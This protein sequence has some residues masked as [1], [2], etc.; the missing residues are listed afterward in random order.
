[1]KIYYIERNNILHGPYELGAMQT[2]LFDGQILLQDKVKTSSGEYTTVRDVL[3][4]NSIKI[5]IKNNG[6]ILKQVKSFGLSLLFPKSAISFKNLKSDQKLLWISII[7]LAP[8]FLIRFTGS[9]IFTFYAIAL[10]FSTLWG[11]FFYT[12]FKTPQVEI[13]KTIKIFF[14]VQL[15]IFS[16][17][18]LF[19][20]QEF[21]PF[22][23][24]L[25]EKNSIFENLLGYIFGVGFFEEMLKLLS[26]YYIIRKSNEPLLPQTIVFYGLISGIGFGVF[27]GIIYQTGINAKLEYNDSFFMNIARLTSLPFLHAIWSGI[28]SYFLSFALL[29]PTNRYSL[30]L[31]AIVIPSLL[32]GI[33]DVFTWS[34][35]GLFVAYIGVTLLFIYLK[36]AKD[37][38]NKILK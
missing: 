21:N 23:R 24:L 11:L 10:Y 26:V 1:M 4:E 16:S 37:F 20:L 33:Y 8:A 9:S 22:Y 7:G 14:L 18:Y 28:S 25:G 6:N 17:F 19:R 36:N 31:I 29:Y 15:L 3:K 2:Y 38:Q 34:L 5:R 27:E 35:P 12:L 13:K 32:H 30:W